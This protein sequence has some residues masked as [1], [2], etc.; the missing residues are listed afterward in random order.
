MG[1]QKFFGC[2]TNFMEQSATSCKKFKLYHKFQEKPKNTFILGGIKVFVTC[3]HCILSL[4]SFL[5]T[6]TSLFIIVFRCNLQRRAMSVTC[7]GYQ[8]FTNCHYYYYYYY[9]PS[10][11]GAYA[12]GWKWRPKRKHRPI[13]NE[14]ENVKYRGMLE[15]GHWQTST[16][17]SQKLIFLYVT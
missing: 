12:P 9:Y 10:I 14:L 17:Y 11:I 13:S 8:C 2:S 16:L 5:F 3:F 4:L 1:R 7:G 6:V 15:V